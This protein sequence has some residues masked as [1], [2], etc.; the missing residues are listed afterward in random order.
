MQTETGVTVGKTVPQFTLDGIDGKSISV[1]AKGKTYV[2]NFWAT[3][4]P[5]CRDEIPELD[6]F[7]LKH[8]NDIQFYAINIEEESKEVA[9][10]LKSN[11]YTFPVLIDKDGAVA[12]TFHVTAI[13]TTL[14]VDSQG[15]IR[16]R[17]TGGVTGEEL[18]KV[19]KGL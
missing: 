2:L 7:A 12:E 8:R 4:C 6:K 11:N 3:W 5:P 18:E 16:Y 10:F 1:G 19:I 13:P 9:D 15:I 17:T 14:V